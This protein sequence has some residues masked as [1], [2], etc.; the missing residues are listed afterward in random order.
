MEG[1][2]PESVR[3]AGL[4]AGHGRA[5]GGAPFARLRRH[6]GGGGLLPRRCG[7]RTW[8]AAVWR[9]EPS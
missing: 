8:A 3:R 5:S 9:S 7:R 4:V 2:C 6:P 1:A